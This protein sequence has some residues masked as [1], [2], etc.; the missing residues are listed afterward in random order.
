MALDKTDKLNP[1]NGS[2]TAGKTVLVVDDSR[3]QRVMLR[4]LMEK[5][6]YIA[7]E[8]ASGLEALE[9]CRSQIPDLVLSDWMMPG[10]DGLEF[11]EAFRRLPRDRYG[12]FILLTSR[13]DK[14]DVTRAFDAGADDFLTKPVNHH[15]LSVRIRAGERILKMEHALN[16]KNR[17]IRITLDELQAVHDSINK[18]LVEAR[19]LQNSLVRERFRDTGHAEV[20]LFLR[21]SGH[22]G[23]DLVGMF[24]VDEDCVGIYGIDVSGHG[25]SSA[26]MTARLAGFLTSGAPD[27]NIA[28]RKTKSGRYVPRE[29]AE[30]MALLNETIINEINTD[31]YFTMLL[32]LF[33]QATGELVFTQAGHPNPI[34]QRASGCLEVVGSGGLPVGL[35]EAAEF[36]E[37]T[38]FLG[39]GDRF[40]IHSDGITEC[41]ESSGDLYGEDGLNRSLLRHASL[42]GQDCIE[43]VIRD[44]SRFSG[45]TEFDDDVSTVL[46]EVKADRDAA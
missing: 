6:G 25:I 28:L 30:T 22:V 21:S 1:P 20:S 3:A 8:A 24:P 29:P 17:L 26:L 19:K 35:I 31:L 38:L 5:Q 27:Q 7:S 14:E 39:A 41:S 36:D 37:C 11:C 4:K 10:M 32:A 15:E 44:M 45:R 46:L 2:V 9:L 16:D 12:Y 42:R 33:N 13:G 40:L 34:V 23:G 43:A 18:D